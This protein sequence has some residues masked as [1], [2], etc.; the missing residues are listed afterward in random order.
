[1]YLGRSPEYTSEV[2][3]MPSTIANTA[4]LVFMDRSFYLLSSSTS[5]LVNDRAAKHHS[6]LENR[7]GGNKR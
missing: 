2:S 1:M 6:Q 3:P 4:I 7:T 5:P